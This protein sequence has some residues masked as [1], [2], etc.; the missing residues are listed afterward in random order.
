MVYHGPNVA[1]ILLYYFFSHTIHLPSKLVLS[2]MSGWP[3]LVGTPLPPGAPWSA[4]G[5]GWP[6][7]LC[8]F[9]IS[10]PDLYVKCFTYSAICLC[11]KTF[12][13]VL[14]EKYMTRSEPLL[15]TRCATSTWCTGSTGKRSSR[16][17]GLPLLNH[18]DQ[19]FFF[20]HCF[21]DVSVWGLPYIL[22]EGS[23]RL[24]VKFR[25]TIFVIKYL[26]WF[27]VFAKYLLLPWQLYKGVRKVIEWT[28][29]ISKNGQF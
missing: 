21:L 4:T 12:I 5:T 17:K 1:L 13:C 7:Y 23:G 2:R 20:I 22:G 28:F 15:R 27:C 18:L 16:M 3:L 24:E 6:G 19:D 14:F 10:I 8:K 26:G 9:T 29:R 25:V 11:L